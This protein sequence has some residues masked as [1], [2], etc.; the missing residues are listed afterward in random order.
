MDF[1]AF[2]E[3]TIHATAMPSDMVEQFGAFEEVT[4][5][6]FGSNNSFGS[7]SFDLLAY[8]EEPELF[9]NSFGKTVST[10]FFQMTYEENVGADRN[11]VFMLWLLV[12][13]WLLFSTRSRYL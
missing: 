12:I 2:E 4:I 9:C 13:K 3:V 8:L 11:Y 7:V 1:G 10:V 6:E 5:H